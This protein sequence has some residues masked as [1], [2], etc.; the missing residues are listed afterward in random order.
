MGV[1]R[2]KPNVFS[3]I[4]MVKVCMLAGQI[5]NGFVWLALAAAS[6]KANAISHNVVMRVRNWG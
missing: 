1:A 2:I 6:S 4:T 5:T 3:Y